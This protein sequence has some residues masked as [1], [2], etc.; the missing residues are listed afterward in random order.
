MPAG[1]DPNIIKP[2][3]AFKKQVLV[4]TASIVLFLVVYLLLLIVT[5]AIAVAGVVAGV[6]LVTTLGHFIVLIFGIGLIFSSLMLV[7]FV[8][9]FLFKSTPVDYSGMAE[10]QEEDH[11]RLFAFIRKVTEEVGAP[12]PKHV[13]I[14]A[15]V[16]AAVFYDSTF[17]SMFFPVKKN[18]KIGLGMVNS[19]NQSEFKAVL[20]HEFGHFSQRS[21]KFGSYVY[22]L[23][24]VIYSM[25]Y[26]N[27]SYGY[28]L[29]AISR[30]HVV[31]R[32]TAYINIG[33]IKAIQFILKQ[34]YVVINK[35]YMG[36]SRQM[37]FHADAV[38]AYVAGSNHVE[39]SLRRSEIGGLCYNTLL[40]YWNKAL[41]SKERSANIY[42]QHR[43]IIE[44]FARQ[45]NMELD[46]SGLPKVGEQMAVLNNSQIVIKEQSSS[47]PPNSEREAHIHRINTQTAPVYNLAWELFDAPEELQEWM[48]NDIYAQTDVRNFSSVNENQFRENYLTKFENNSFDK[49]YKGYYDGRHITKF[50]LE[51]P[52][53]ESLFVLTFSELFSDANCNIPQ[54]IEGLKQ[55]INTVDIIA[56]KN[57]KINTFDFKGAKYSRRQTPK[58]KEQLVAE[59]EAAEVRMKELDKAAYHY[60]TTV[61]KDDGERQALKAGYKQLFE[62]QDEMNED[63]S[64]Y[65]KLMQQISPIYS[66]MEF[67]AINH[68]L[69]R[70]Y[71]TEAQIKPRLQHLVNDDK[72]KTYISTEQKIALEKYLG[73]D[74]KYF[75]GVKYDEAAIAVFN[76][77]MT[78]YINVIVERHFQLKKALLNLQVQLV[79]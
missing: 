61:A 44:Q 45:Y 57:Y 17:W 13:Y 2:S 42:P 15:D 46:Q 34:L 14:S 51:A 40:D 22:N 36:L 35:S 20:A 71:T 7:Y 10:I 43:V 50:D 64:L 30:F 25:L 69:K 76:E 18:L 38:A 70:V 32:I 24:K 67:A 52:Q 33:I 65:E 3:A 5:I 23:N 60:F 63:I 59:L 55:D 1:A 49:L 39:T 73:N 21:M 72:F 68:T 48:T 19:V 79:A 16:N 66:T 75:D 58:V 11:P 4:V 6:L 26:D 9:K 78:A 41:K 74:W 47:H 8:V 62:A 12:F 37:E 31:L 77:A 53:P 29:N 27:E 28:A 56:D 54:Q